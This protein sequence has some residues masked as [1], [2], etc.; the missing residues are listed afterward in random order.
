VVINEKAKREKDRFYPL[1][2]ND[3]TTDALS[4]IEE[5]THRRISLKA[6]P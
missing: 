1:F 4:L 5:F 6:K 3:E 2:T